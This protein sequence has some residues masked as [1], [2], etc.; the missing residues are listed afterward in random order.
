MIHTAHRT[1]GW[2]TVIV[3]I[4]VLLTACGTS[5]N[6]K[7]GQD[8]AQADAPQS[9]E[10][11]VYKAANGDITIP[12]NPQRI[13][14]AASSYVGDFLALGIKPVGVTS[15]A[16]E[17]PFFKGKVDGIAD[18]GDGQSVEKVLDLRPDLIIAFTGTENLDQ[19]S[20]VAPTVAIAYGKKNYKEELLEF[21]KMTNKEAEAQAW[22]TA[23][24]KKIAE[25]KS[26]VEAAVGSKTVSI[27]N[28]YAKGIY[29]FGHNYGRGGEIIYGEFKLK[30]PPIVQK[31]AIDSGQ[32]WA[33]LSLE[34][35][36]EYAGDYIFTCPWSGDSA[37]PEVVYGSALW[38]GLPAVKANH[39][40]QLDPKGALYNDPISL[41]AQLAFITDK[42]TQTP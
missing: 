2:M 7:Q 31:E 4:M 11:V 35:L 20:K 39:V 10:T 21:G 12:K 3:L 14:V 29:A 17:N 13:V 40:F 24:D 9:G 27:L 16:L 32:G 18:I 19:L 5:G 22:I 33:N 30:A 6:S 15:D 26:K 1:K 41:E 37:D 23:W 34:K 25:S 36:P 8:S 42:L 28:P 38:K